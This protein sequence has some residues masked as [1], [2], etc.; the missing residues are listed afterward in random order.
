MSPSSSP[1]KTPT[2]SPVAGFVLV[3]NDHCRDASKNLYS[4]VSAAFSNASDGVC[5]NWCNQNPVGR[6]VCV[7]VQQQ[8]STEKRC[9]CLFSGGI[10]KSI[11]TNANAYEP[12]WDLAATQSGI[13]EVQ[14]TTNRDGDIV[15]Y[16]TLS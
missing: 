6:F 7:E 10:P 8:T 14:T 12:A 9:Y 2:A 16:K 1:S 5:L 15:C 3:G 11:K 4:S 13:G